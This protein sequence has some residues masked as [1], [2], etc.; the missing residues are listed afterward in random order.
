[1]IWISSKSKPDNVFLRMLLAKRVLNNFFYAIQLIVL[2]QIGKKLQ[3]NHNVMKMK[4]DSGKPRFTEIVLNLIM[5]GMNAKLKMMPLMK[6]L[7][8]IY[9]N[10]LIAIAPIGWLWKILNAHWSMMNGWPKVTENVINQWM[11][12]PNVRLMMSQEKLM[13]SIYFVIQVEK[14]FHLKRETKENIEIN[15]PALP[16][17]AKPW[18]FSLDLYLF[19]TANY[20][21]E[22]KH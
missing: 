22:E 10:L 9:V 13:K 1:M 15:L 20:F 11:V 4:V 8:I 19:C 18:W 6:P 21:V 3:M 14:W 17:K 12:D 5:V 2:V 16:V 7:N